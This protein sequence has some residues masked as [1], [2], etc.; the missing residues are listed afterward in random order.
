MYVSKKKILTKYINKY[1]TTQY[2]LMRNMNVDTTFINKKGTINVDISIFCYKEQFLRE[3][4]INGVSQSIMIDPRVNVIS[5][6]FFDYPCF[7]K[8]SKLPI[9]IIREEIKP[10]IKTIFN[11][12]LNELNIILRLEDV[13]RESD[14]Q[15]ATQTIA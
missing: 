3:L 7:S 15:D 8:N 2:P 13:S 14:K 1:V 5:P 9:S 12:K 10:F 6:F 11:K 4:S